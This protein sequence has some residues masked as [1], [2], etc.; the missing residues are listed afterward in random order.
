MLSVSASLSLTHATKGLH[1]LLQPQ[2]RLQMAS[3]PLWTWGYSSLWP[4]W[5]L[6]MGTQRDAADI[7]VSCNS[8]IPG[9]SSDLHQSPPRF[10][11]QPCSQQKRTKRSTAT[12][13]HL[14]KCTQA[15]GLHTSASIVTHQYTCENIGKNPEK[16]KHTSQ[17]RLVY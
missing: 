6:L 15:P 17:Q 9:A 2:S 1:F 8:A 13:W 12:P 11:P 5:G 16:P 10:S 14:T 3:T 7:R 4:L